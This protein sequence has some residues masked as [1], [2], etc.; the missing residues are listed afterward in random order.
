MKWRVANGNQNK[1]RPEYDGTRQHRLDR[2]QHH[3]QGVLLQDR[4]RINQAVRPPG[5]RITKR[6]P[7]QRPYDQK[8]T[9]S[10]HRRLCPK[11]HGKHDIQHQVIRRNDQQRLKVRPDNT[12]HSTRMPRRDFS[13][14]KNGQQRPGSPKRLQ[15]ITETVFQALDQATQ[16]AIAEIAHAFSNEALIPNKITSLRKKPLNSNTWI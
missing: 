7:R 2:K 12:R 16:K 9:H 13:P 15:I 11:P 5:H 10:P 8:R 3:G 14:N 1:Q 4:T 6:H